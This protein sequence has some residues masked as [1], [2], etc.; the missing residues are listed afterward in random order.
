MQSYHFLLTLQAIIAP[1]MSILNRFN[2]IC[3]EFKNS[4]EMISGELN[5]FDYLC[6]RKRK[7]SRAGR[8]VAC[9][10]RGARGK[11]GHRRTLRFLTGSIREGAATQ[12]KTTALLYINKVRVRTRGKSSRPQPVMAAVCVAEGESACKPAT[13][14]C[15]S[16]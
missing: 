6:S 11:S 7:A 12:K 8:S 4:L 2:L 16:E 5:F 3:E 9:P 14:G 15:P 13:E 10:V 1:N